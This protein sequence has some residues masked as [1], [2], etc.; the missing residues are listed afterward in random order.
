[1]AKI[2]TACE[3]CGRTINFDSDEKE[4]KD[5]WKCFKCNQKRDL[6]TENDCYAE[7]QKNLKEG[8]W[9]ICKRENPSNTGGSPTFDYVVF[10]YL[11]SK[12]LIRAS[13]SRETIKDAMD[14]LFSHSWDN[15]SINK[16]G[17]NYLQPVS[18][19]TEWSE[20]SMVF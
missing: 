7:I 1:M 13:H 14:D 16:F 12:G 5:W 3:W 17:F 15:D 19:M 6:A 18:P 2:T 8:K 20:A 4:Q 10:T 9:V 11:D